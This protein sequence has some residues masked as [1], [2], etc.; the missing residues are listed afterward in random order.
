MANYGENKGKR[1]PFNMHTPV[2]DKN[3]RGKNKA[4]GLRA[5]RGKPIA[6]D[7]G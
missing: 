3:Q 6:I 2:K 4:E 7:H 5:S 1:K